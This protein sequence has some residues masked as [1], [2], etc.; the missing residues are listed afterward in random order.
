VDFHPRL[1][2]RRPWGSREDRNPAA[3]FRAAVNGYDQTAGENRGT[4]R[5]KSK[6]FYS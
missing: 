4:A 3:V 2:G 6:T 1:R 5:R